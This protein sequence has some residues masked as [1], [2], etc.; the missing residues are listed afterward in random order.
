MLICEN[1]RSTSLEPHFGQGGDGFV[2]IE[3]NSS[4]RTRHFSQRYS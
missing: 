4:K 1:T 3:R 2:E